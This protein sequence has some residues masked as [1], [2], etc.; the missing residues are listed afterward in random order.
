MLE[1]VN[2]DGS[3]TG[4]EA[5]IDRIVTHKMQP[6]LKRLQKQEQVIQACYLATDTLF[7][8]FH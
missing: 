7:E 5:V 8:K 3:L 4:V 2:A 6:L 1:E